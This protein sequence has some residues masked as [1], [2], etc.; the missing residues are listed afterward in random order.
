MNWKT[1]ILILFLTA[2]SS[3][4]FGDATSGSPSTAKQDTVAKYYGIQTMYE[5]KVID[6]STLP[7]SVTEGDSVRPA[8]TKEGVTIVTL[9]DES[10][11]ATAITNH[12]LN[13]TN[14]ASRQGTVIVGYEAK[15]LDGSALPS[16]V[17]EG[18]AVR[19][20]ASLHG[21]AYVCSVNENGSA[22]SS[23][24]SSTTAEYRATTT[25]RGDGTVTYASAT[26]LTFAG[27][28]YT[29]A[30]ED[31]VYI[32]EVDATAN[33]ATLWVNGSGGVHMEFSG[34]TLTRSGGSD[35]SANGAY[36]VGYNCTDKSYDASNNA[37][38]VSVINR[39]SDKDTYDTLASLTNIAASTSGQL[40]IDIEGYKRVGLQCNV[41]SGTV[42][43]IR[44]A[45]EVSVQNDGT[46]AASCTYFD[47]TES[48]VDLITGTTSNADYVNTDCL[49]T[50]SN[51]V[52]A[53]YLMVSYITDGAGSDQDLTIYSCKGE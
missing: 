3:Y 29:I 8:A 15:D 23:G 38:R 7:N 46:A 47:V 17:S 27:S 40:Y 37:T 30:S 39:D 14:F 9:A 22:L 19:P 10:G 32:R 44:L 11:V 13:I 49:I 20:A 24:A 34:S 2:M 21:V 52:K 45:F 41:S 53:K 12:D 1:K 6:G 16:S 48:T 50:F 31:L 25:G 33:T 35:F 18:D 26:P 28:P 51:L 42:G 5:A 43:S 4:S 36:E